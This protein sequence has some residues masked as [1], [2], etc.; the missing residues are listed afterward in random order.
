[1][2]F[3]CTFIYTARPYLDYSSLY[4]R[5]DQRLAQGS[6]QGLHS[7]HGTGSGSK[8]LVQEA[9]R[10]LCT[11]GFTSWLSCFKVSMHVGTPLL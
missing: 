8:D 1:M 10:T 6:P 4:I 5:L 7:G 2:G 3:R 11:V 9:P